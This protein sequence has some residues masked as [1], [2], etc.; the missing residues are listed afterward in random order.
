MKLD[1]FITAPWN[2][3]PQIVNEK[4]VEVSEKYLDADGEMTLKGMLD[5]MQECAHR[6]L[7]A[8]GLSVEKLMDKGMMLFVTRISCKMS[9]MPKRREVLRTKTWTLPERRAGLLRYHTM[10]T[11]DGERVIDA[12]SQ[13]VCVDVNTRKLISPQGFVDAWN[14]PFAEM[15]N[16]CPRPKRLRETCEFTSQNEIIINRDRLDFYGHVNNSEY[17][18]FI[19]EISSIKNPSGFRITYASEAKLGDVLDI[20]SGGDEKSTYFEAEFDRGVCFKAKVYFDGEVDD[21][22]I[23]C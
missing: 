11:D 3:N 9:R 23:F 20:K 15:A 2:E 18:S 1:S 14:A 6:H 8:V 19:D 10:D 12:V 4:T 21:A 5:V 7:G 17:A 13:W 16:G 22:E